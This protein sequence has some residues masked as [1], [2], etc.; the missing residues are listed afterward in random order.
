MKG[1]IVVSRRPGGSVDIF[2]RTT[3]GVLR[4]LAN[5]KDPKPILEQIKDDHPTI[6]IDAKGVMY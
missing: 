2:H 4:L 3:A 1:N 6:K 5:T